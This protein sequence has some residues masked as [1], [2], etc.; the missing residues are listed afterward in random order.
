MPRTRRMPRPDTPDV[1][2]CAL[3]APRPP[4]SHPAAL[5]PCFLFAVGHV[6][7]FVVNSNVCYTLVC[8]TR[9]RWGVGKQGLFAQAVPRAFWYRRGLIRAAFAYDKRPPW[10]LWKPPLLGSGL[11]WGW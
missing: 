1:S 9:Q 2:A 7:C 4:A 6:F 8:L 11:A 5:L 10:R 3:A